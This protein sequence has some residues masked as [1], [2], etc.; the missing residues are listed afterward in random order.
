MNYTNDSIKI[1]EDNSFI[2]ELHYPKESEIN[3]CSD[4]NEIINCDFYYK[5]NH[6]ERPINIITIME[7]D[8]LSNSKKN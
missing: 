4:Y 1:N 2:E 5:I 3:N 8:D 6:P 7:S